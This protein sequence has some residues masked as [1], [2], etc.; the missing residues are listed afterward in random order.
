[1]SLIP[2]EEASGPLLL[3]T[4]RV[5]ATALLSLEWFECP[6]TVAEPGLGCEQGPFFQARRRGCCG[7]L[8]K[9]RE[10]SLCWG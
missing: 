10:Q 5:S 9:K 7:T 8:D 4:F 2:T 1:M 3:E 6:A